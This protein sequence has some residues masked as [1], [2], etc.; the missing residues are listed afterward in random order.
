MLDTPDTPRF[1]ADLEA[2]LRDEVN[3]S[4]ASQRAP[5]LLTGVVAIVVLVVVLGL[6]G[7]NGGGSK[8]QATA[9]VLGD[10]VVALSALSDP[11]RHEEL[12][13]RFAD[14]GG[15]LVI[16]RRP[17]ADQSVGQVLGV[18]LPRGIRLD[19]DRLVDP[20][21]MSGPVVVTLGVPSPTPTTAGAPIY[22]TL[23]DLCE[24]VEPTDAPAT[25]AALR[26]A[27]YDIDVKL[28]EFVDDGA[29]ARDVAEPPAGTL[30]I[31]VMDHRGENAGVDPDT[32]RLIVEVGSGGQ[33]HSGQTPSSCLPGSATPS[34]P[35][36]RR[37]DPGPQSLEPRYEVPTRPEP[38]ID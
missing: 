17:V 33:G 25:V 21:K 20:S 15:R 1:S 7:V 23:P 13:R 3:S 11:E 12:Q 27:G 18:S 16:E 19:E 30:V 22:D 8:A 34:P 36:A 26:A 24:L 28:I 9:F 10:D 38:S 29:E 32:R 35:A 31:G 37:G 5:R 14:E 2:Y 6:T 4:S